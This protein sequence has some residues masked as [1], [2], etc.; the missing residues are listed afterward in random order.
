MPQQ[1]A[2][3][4]LSAHSRALERKPSEQWGKTQAKATKGCMTWRLWVSW[5]HPDSLLSDMKRKIL[6]SEFSDRE[7]R[8]GPP[9]TVFPAR[10]CV[11]PHTQVAVH[12]PHI[13]GWM[14]P[15]CQCPQQDLMNL[16]GCGGA[17]VYQLGLYHAWPQNYTLPTGNWKPCRNLILLCSLCCW[18]SSGCFPTLRRLTILAPG[19]LQRPRT[20]NKVT[21]PV[22]ASTSQDVR[23]CCKDRSQRIVQENI[24]FDKRFGTVVCIAA[25]Q[26]RLNWFTL[27]NVCITHLQETDLRHTWKCCKPKMSSYQEKSHFEAEFEEVMLTMVQPSPLPSNFTTG[28]LYTQ[29]QTIPFGINFT[30]CLIGL[31]SVT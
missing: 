5:P 20:N 1:R 18:V 22:H 24:F 26:P 4:N 19:S 23:I 3:W 28:N 25:S 12:P 11:Q 30:A 10:G 17:G 31:H 16:N 9:P 21:G 8:H 15:L 13:H 27:H 6:T 14:L 2:S 7:T 29:L